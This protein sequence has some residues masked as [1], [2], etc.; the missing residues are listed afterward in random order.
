MR[1]NV[2]HHDIK[3]DNM[4]VDHRGNLKITDFGTAI[5]LKTDDDDVLNNREWGTKLFLP[6]ESWDCS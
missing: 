6:P 5:V 2:S 4:L 1:M 3:P